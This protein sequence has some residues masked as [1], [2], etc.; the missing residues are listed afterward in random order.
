MQKDLFN[1]IFCRLTA[2]KERL[3]KDSA[4]LESLS[5]LSVLQRGYSITRSVVSGVIVR[6][7]ACLNVGDDVNVRLAKGEFN[8]KIEK[9]F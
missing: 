3:L 9:I 1:N 5:P 6:E 7:T 4:V 2:I 8:A